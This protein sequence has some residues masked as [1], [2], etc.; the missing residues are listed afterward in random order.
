MKQDPQE[1]L[2]PD[3]GTGEGSGS[4][5]DSAYPVPDAL[6]ES[7]PAARDSRGQIDWPRVRQ[8]LEDVARSLR[9]E[10]SRTSDQEHTLLLERARQLARPIFEQDS[11]ARLGLLFVRLG[12][13]SFGIRAGEVA[14]VVRGAEIAALPGSPGPVVALSAW[15]GRLL[16]TLDVRALLGEPS[17]ATTNLL[18]LGG[19]IDVGLLVDAVEDLREVELNTVRPLPP[20]GSPSGILIEVLADGTPLLDISAVLRLARTTSRPE[21]RTAADYVPAP[22]RSDE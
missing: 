17:P 22:H 21:Q 12:N 8:R 18:V 15:R 13:S 14:A 7:A 11:S 9:Q 4:E 2:R 1:A 3:D 5:T 6:R 20:A 16:P 19:E 10:G